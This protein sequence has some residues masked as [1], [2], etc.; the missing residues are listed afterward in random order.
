MGLADRILL[1]SGKGQDAKK[2]RD[3]RALNSPLL[4]AVTIL[5]KL[6]ARRFL[7]VP[8]RRPATS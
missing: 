2:G 4:S 8:E 6:A 3:T 1:P 5:G 7:E